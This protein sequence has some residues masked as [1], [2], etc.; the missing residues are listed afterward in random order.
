MVS[1]LIPLAKIYFKHARNNEDRIYSGRY[2]RPTVKLEQ[3]DVSF[4]C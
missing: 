4:L 3:N 2:A 1:K